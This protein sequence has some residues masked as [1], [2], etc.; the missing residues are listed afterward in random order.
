MNVIFTDKIA[1]L[2]GT[3]RDRKSAPVEGLTIIAFPQDEKRWQPQSR[4]IVTARSDKT[5]A[6]RINMLPPGDYF[7]VAVDDV[8][9][10]EWFDPGFL[11]RVKDA[12]TKLTIGEG[13]QRTEDLKAP[14]L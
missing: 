1:S 7:V 5:G 3:V 12:A 14:S 10:G 2:A 9:Q 4:Q 8:E 13:E 11:E 6:Y